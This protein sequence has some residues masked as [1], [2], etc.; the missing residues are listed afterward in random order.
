MYPIPGLT[1]GTPT[2]NSTELDKNFIR[3]LENFKLESKTSE[4]TLNESWTRRP[5]LRRNV[6]K[7]MEE[8]VPDKF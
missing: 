2:I 6:R 5:G 8:I 1:P 7:M 3:A 4:Y